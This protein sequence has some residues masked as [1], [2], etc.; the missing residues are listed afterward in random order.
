M[1]CPNRCLFYFCRV[2]LFR[3]SATIMGN[4]R[5]VFKMPIH[6]EDV[7]ISKEISGLRSALIVPCI[8]CPAAT[9]AVR[10][11]KPFLALF[12]SFLKSPPLEQY[13]SELQSR[14]REHGITTKVFK[15][16]LY[17]HWFLCMWTLSR[18]NKLKKEAEEYDAVIVLGCDSASKTVSDAVTSNGCKVIEGM[19]TAGIMNAQISFH[20]PGNINFEN[21]KIVPISQKRIEKEISN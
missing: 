3:C 14:L 19:Q 4:G 20:W 10:R 12:S 7:D 18:R 21:C 15:S 13:L 16:L 9:L 5:L 1:T 17:H 6:F 2:L 11:D 8:M